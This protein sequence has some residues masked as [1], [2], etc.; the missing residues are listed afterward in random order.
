MLDDLPAILAGR[1]ILGLAVIG[2]TT[3]VTTL[4]ADYYTGETRTHLMGLEITARNLGAVVFLPVSGVLADA[5]WRAPFLAYP[6]ALGLLPLIAI[7]IFDTTTVRPKRLLQDESAAPVRAVA[8]GVLDALQDGAALPLKPII[9]SYSIIFVVQVLFFLIPVFLPFYL[10]GLES[11]SGAQTGFSMA[12]YALATAAAAS[13]YGYVKPRFH[14]VSLIAVSLGLMGVGWTSIGV[15][16][17]YVPVLTGLAVGGV[18]MGL[19]IPNLHVWLASETPVS[20]RGRVLGGFTMALFLGQFMSPILTQPVRQQLG[21]G[22]TYTCSGALLIALTL[23]AV[24]FRRDFS[25]E[26]GS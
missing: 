22:A 23:A 7:F 17:S 20:L 16:S 24:I 26:G 21:L 15:A 3:S 14:F 10:Q 4:I 6:I 19:L 8:P 5:G 13:A 18:G 9:L 1:A 2:I 25:P 11:A 12:L